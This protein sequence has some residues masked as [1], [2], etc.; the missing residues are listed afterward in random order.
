MYVYVCMYV[1]VYNYACVYV[2]IM[3]VYVCTLNYVCMCVCICRREGR[4]QIFIGL[5]KFSNEG[6]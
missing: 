6:D 4:L 5:L 1:C 3:H 2:C